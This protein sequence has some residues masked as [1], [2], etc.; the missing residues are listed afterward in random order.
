MW[1][2][3]FD[4]KSEGPAGSESPGDDGGWA[5]FGEAAPAQV[6]PASGE[7]VKK[8]AGEKTFTKA[9]LLADSDDDGE[10]E[11]ASAEPASAKPA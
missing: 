3:E 10:E 9:E 11:W 5:D 2:A 1:A 8:D 7:E 6:A 4:T